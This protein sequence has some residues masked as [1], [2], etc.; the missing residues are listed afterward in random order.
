MDYNFLPLAADKLTIIVDGN[1]KEAQYLHFSKGFNE[2]VM[3]VLLELTDD[4]H[5]YNAEYIVP[6]EMFLPYVN[7]INAKAEAGVDPLL[8]LALFLS[9][10]YR[11]KNEQFEKMSADEK[12]TFDHLPKLYTI[13]KEF[14]AKHHGEYVATVISE[15]KVVTDMFGGKHFQITGPF[16]M[17]TGKH[18]V[19]KDK[20]FTISQF[21]GLRYRKDLPVMLLEDFPEKKTDLVERGK[22]FK[23]YGL[24]A[25]H[26]HYTGNMFRMSYYG[27]V[28]FKAEG[29]CMADTVGYDA[30]N[31]SSS[32][33]YDMENH[34]YGGHKAANNV[35]D[36]DL[37]EEILHRTWPILR[38]FSFAS[39]SWGEMFV[40]NASDIKFDD[41]AFEYLVLPQEKK[42]LAKALITNVDKCFTDIITGKSGGC[43]FLLYGPPGTGKTLTCE[44]IAELLHRPLYSITVGE[45]GITP[46]DLE[47]KLVQILDIANSWDAVILIDEADIFL[48]KRTEHDIV[49]NAMVGIFLRLLERHQGVMFL[50]TNRA[51][52]MDEAFRSRISVV[53]EYEKLSQDTKYKVWQNL[54]NASKV[55]IKDADVHKL[56]AHELNG[57]QIKNAIRMAQC[58]AFD[59]KEEFGFDQLQTVIKHM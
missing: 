39:K 48:E 35:C 50:T 15:T 42:E 46:Q 33:R 21:G 32:G 25:K 27:P 59:R 56:L 2:E 31:P 4:E 36:A 55:T 49:R 19:L 13:G 9:E 52:S 16:I 26:V 58:L 12:I 51:N 34:N 40:R 28:Y 37:P 23:K 43:I 20:T 5:F 41:N 38:G 29:R 3:K 45:L 54:L 18:F 6:V 17:S 14:L 10:Y 30:M 53:F 1:V 57:R 11:E 8:P 24:G 22:L 7:S 47:H 44:A